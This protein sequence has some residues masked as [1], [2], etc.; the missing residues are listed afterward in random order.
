[1]SLDITP[2]RTVARVIHVS[3]DRTTAYIELRNGLTA[4]CT[5]EQPFEFTH[6]DVVFVDL[7]SNSVEKAPNDVW[8]ED[9]WVG[10]V[11]LLLPDRVVIDIG[12][13]LRILSRAGYPD[14][15]EGNTIEGR[16]SAGIT[17][18]QFKM[19]L[20]NQCHAR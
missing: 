13:R 8:P 12:G 17:Q 7:D 15:R 20:R 19:T 18:G 16:D 14:L 4:T 11:R 3:S 2:P 9:S 1:M 5:S 10:V 6:G